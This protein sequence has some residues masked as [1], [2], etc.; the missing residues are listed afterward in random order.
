MDILHP[1]VEKVPN[2]PGANMLSQL[3]S[4]GAVGMPLSGPDPSAALKGSIASGAKQL[5]P[6]D[7]SNN[8]PLQG[9]GGGT[10]QVSVCPGTS[11]HVAFCR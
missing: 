2:S 6:S 7:G 3:S 5:R 11:V 10:A 1:C 9:I 4:A 8:I